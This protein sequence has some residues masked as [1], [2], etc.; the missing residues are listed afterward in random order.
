MCRRRIDAEGGP[1]EG[2]TVPLTRET[3]HGAAVKTDVTFQKSPLQ[4]VSVPDSIFTW[5]SIP[6]LNVGG[7][8]RLR[9][10]AAANPCG[11]GEQI[12]APSVYARRTRTAG[13]GSP[14]VAH[15]D[16]GGTRFARG[17]TARW[18]SRPHRKRSRR[19]HPNSRRLRRQ[20]RHL[21]PPAIYIRYRQTPVGRQITESG[22]TCRFR[23]RQAFTY[24]YR[25]HKAFILST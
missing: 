24:L 3:G 12:G 6:T 2:A 21:K 8:T 18:A 17:V 5:R 20:Q 22:P 23:P 14:G 7:S 11:G 1:I 16:L 25:P 4:G 19:R 13:Y 10:R 9:E 15:G